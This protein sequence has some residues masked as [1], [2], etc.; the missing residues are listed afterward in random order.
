MHSYFLT[1]WKFIHLT[2]FNI[3]TDLIFYIRLLRKINYLKHGRIKSIF[4][5]KDIF[6]QNH[7]I[8]IVRL[9]E[10]SD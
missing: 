6:L 7:E 2:D 8:V 10:N 3:S 4:A 9:L 5:V 1:M